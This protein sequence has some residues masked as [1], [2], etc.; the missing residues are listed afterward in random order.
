M[1]EDKDLDALL[2]DLQQNPESAKLDDL[3]AE[4]IEKLYN[5]LNPYAYYDSLAGKNGIHKV[6]FMSQTNLRMEYM[7]KLITTAMTGFLFAVSK[8]YNAPT[9]IRR[10]IPKVKKLDKNDKADVGTAELVPFNIDTT[11]SELKKTLALAESV[12]K[13]Q[14]NLDE[15]RD[16]LKIE[17]KL[18]DGKPNQRL[19]SMVV[20]EKELANRVKVV[21][22]LTTHQIRLLGIAADRDMDY[23]LEQL[24]GIPQAEEL[25]KKYPPR[26]VQWYPREHTLE[27]PQS[28]V[29]NILKDFL[30][31]WFEF[32][33]NKDVR[34]AYDRKKINAD[35]TPDGKLDKVDPE[36]PTPNAIKFKPNVN[37]VDLESYRTIVTNKKDKDAVIHVIRDTNLRIIVKD[38]LSDSKTTERF[39]SYLSHIP[40]D[41]PARVVAEIVPPQDTYHRFNYYFDVNYEEIRSA[42]ACY[43]NEKPD[44]EYMTFIHKVVEGTE[45]EIEKQRQQFKSEHQDSIKVDV[46]SIF[47]GKWCMLGSFKKNREKL[48]FYN[49]NTKVLQRILERIEDDRKMGKELMQNRV[50]HAKA[51]NIK[52]D[53]PDAPGLAAYKGENKEFAAHGVQQV[54]SPEHMK[55]LEKAKGNIKAAKELEYIEQ[56]E[57]RMKELEEIKK[58]RNWNETEEKEVTSLIEDIKHAKEMLNVPDNAVQVDIHT[59]DT[60]SGNFSKTH[61][62]TKAQVPESQD[63]KETKK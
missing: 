14:K 62:Y 55:R 47:F 29:T 38:I 32:D 6:A 17:E 54:I 61:F 18:S 45:E 15:I 26:S 28:V 20:N 59:F 16:S 10:W 43:Y 8:E 53:G 7:Q 56:K 5:K 44:I 3:P 37:E 46:L 4:T 52:S 57:Q 31:K 22:Y 50:I 30:K 58:Q 49:E 39:I 21:E 24:H 34:E 40:M 60:T 42:V 48:D 23:T 1:S 63:T 2:S 11:I 51:D 33:P 36:R 25:L 9:E 35:L 27:V 41:S 19:M 13:E 12:K